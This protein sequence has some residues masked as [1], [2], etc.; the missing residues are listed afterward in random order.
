MKIPEAGR[1]A[2]LVLKVYDLDSLVPAE[3]EAAWKN[4]TEPNIGSC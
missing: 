4:R 2:L 1:K 3:K